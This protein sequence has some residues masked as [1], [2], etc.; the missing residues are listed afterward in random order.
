MHRSIKTILLGVSSM[1]LLTGCSFDPT[2]LPIVGSM[3][4]VK[5]VN[6]TLKPTPKSEVVTDQ[7]YVRT[8]NEEYYKTYFPTEDNT[9]VKGDSLWFDEDN[10]AAFNDDDSLI[11]TLYADDELIYYSENVVP[12]TYTIHRY[13]DDGWSIGLRDLKVSETGR[14]QYKKGTS[15]AIATS[16]IASSLANAKGG[17]GEDTVLT[18]ESFN[19]TPIKE[20]NLSKIGT[21]TGLDKKKEYNVDLYV[22]SIYNKIVMNADTHFL[23][24][25]EEYSCNDYT[26]S[27]KNV[28]KI[29]L[30]HDLQNGYYLI[31]NK[32][33]FKYINEPRPSIASQ[34]EISNENEDKENYD[35][36][37]PYFYKDENG[38]KYTYAQ[39]QELNGEEPE[40]EK[41]SLDQ[42][43]AFYVAEN[44]ANMSIDARYQD[45]SL[46]RAVMQVTSPSGKTS[47][48]L[49][50]SD[51]NYV[52]FAFTANEPEM[53]MW[54]VQF[55][56]CGAQKIQLQFSTLPNTMDSSG[57]AQIEPDNATPEDDTQSASE[58]AEKQLNTATAQT[59]T[60]E[61]GQ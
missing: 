3:I 39:W 21:I 35:F 23:N 50:L 52:Q 17:G 32:A 46:S 18:F 25:W 61:T 27:N 31:N 59:E 1:A 44:Q 56:N 51:G 6:N 26:L 40:Y 22:G 11:P 13:K 20:S 14:I 60:T 43:F 7:F 45:S 57:Y 19:K 30:P 24:A 34:S 38:T 33:F 12:E 37:I 42:E 16:T 49:S 15:A 36:N 48:Q 2:T 53:G 47:E 29:N 5:D 4:A 54:K 58:I 55:Y 8:K 10:Q 41:D 9:S 28:A